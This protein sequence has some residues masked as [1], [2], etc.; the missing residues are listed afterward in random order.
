MISEGVWG[1]EILTLVGISPARLQRPRDWQP[2]VKLLVVLH[3]DENEA[4]EV[5]YAAKQPTIAE[6]R[7]LV[8]REKELGLLLFW[9]RSA[10]P[11]KRRPPFQAI[12]DTPYFVGRKTVLS[13]LKEQ[14]LNPSESAICTLQGMAGTGKTTIAARLAYQ[15][16][17]HFPDGVL[18]ARLDTSDTMTILQ[19]FAQAYG[20]DVSHY[21]DVN[22]RS[23]VMRE[24]LADKQALIILDNAL[25]SMSIEPLLPPTGK[26]AV[27]VTSRRYDL[28]AMRGASQF[29]LSSFLAESETVQQLFI[30]FLGAK[31]VKEESKSLAAI[32][33]YVG[34]LPL[35][36]A[37]I[38]GRLAYEPDWSAQDFLARLQQK[39]RRLKE[40]KYEDQSVRLSFSSSY[41]LLPDEEQSFLAISAHFGGKDFSPS[42]IAAAAALPLEDA[43]DHLRTLYTLSLIQAGRSGRYALHPL[44]RDYAREHPVDASAWMRKAVYFINFMGRH[45]SGDEQL[46]MESDNILAMLNDA[47]ERGETAV[48]IQLITGFVPYLKMQGMY[49]LAERQLQHALELETN[50]QAVPI[51]I[52]LVQIA[53]HRRDYDM[54]DRYLETAVVLTKNQNNTRYL[55]AIQTEKGIIASCRGNYA[56]AQK[57]FIK[58]LTFARSDND[59]AI[60]VPLLKELGASELAH[61]HYQQAKLY[62]QEA[63]TLAREQQPDHVPALLRCLGGV[64]IS[65]DQDFARA[66]ELYTEGLALARSM[67]SQIDIVLLL[68]NLALIAFQKEQMAD[69]ETLLLEGLALARSLFHQTSV[70]ML[71][72]NLGR[73]S[74]HKQEWAQAERYMQEGLAVGTAVFHHGLIITLHNSLGLLTGNQRQY[75]QAENHFHEALSRAQKINRRPLITAALQRWGWLYTQQQNDGI[76][77]QFP[78]IFPP[79]AATYDLAQSSEEFAAVYSSLKS[80]RL[81]FFYD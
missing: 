30:N 19:T 66:E 47:R 9:E 64:A 21:A 38:A 72:G 29:S 53:R 7:L 43:K 8:T 42:A 71:L 15:L 6:L 17:P 76:A 13:Q 80:E 73:L 77:S 32:A 50:S 25:N 40:L 5:L 31:Q 46:S 78:E 62:Y 39:S 49:D 33:E 44:L 37:I 1:S 57:H 68:N 56:R 70:G 81:K 51:L 58:G 3:L 27:L 28:R 10:A 69:A 34:Y 11:S 79:L 41:D 59:P 16:R 24:L 65:R 18:W 45:K 74:A 67:N 61:D 26:C 52:Y 60:L 36:L 22:S 54:A 12:A 35:A 4:N 20:A 48:F 14:L 63:L 23:R 2:I 55:S 75:Q